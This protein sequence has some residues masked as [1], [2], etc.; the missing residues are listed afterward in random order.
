MIIDRINVFKCWILIRESRVTAIV[1]HNGDIYRA[2]LRNTGKLQDLIYPGSQVLCSFKSSG[3]TS[4]NIVGV[5][6]NDEAVLVDTYIQMKMFEKACS[7]GLI[8]WLKECTIRNREVK[9]K[10]GR[11][12]YRIE[13]NGVEGFLELKSA[14]LF[15]DG[16]AMYPDT[17]SKRGLKHILLLRDLR[18]EGYRAIIAFI[19]AH[20]KAEAFKP[21]VEVDKRIGYELKEAIKTGVE[22][23]AVKMYLKLDGTIVIEDPNVRCEII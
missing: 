20:P 15:K 21:Y 1:K 19:V 2:L 4:I 11:I 8:P 22:V 6:V 5:I 18:K 7:I 12:D 10:G 9:V 3:R 17:P 16:Y 14:V 13:C 23:Y